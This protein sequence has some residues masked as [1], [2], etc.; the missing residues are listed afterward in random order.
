[1]TGALTWARLSFRQQKW[2][3]LLVLL[4]VVGSAA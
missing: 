3:L 1:V 4:A 2:E